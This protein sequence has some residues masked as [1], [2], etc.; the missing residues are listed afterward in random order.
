MRIRRPTIRGLSVGVFAVCLLFP[1]EAQLSG[2]NRLVPFENILK[3]TQAFLVVDLTTLKKRSTSKLLQVP[4]KEAL[5]FEFEEQSVTVVDVLH[6]GDKLKDGRLKKGAS[7]RFVSVAVQR[8]CDYQIT[9]ATTGARRRMWYDHN[10]AFDEAP[11]GSKALLLLT[12]YDGE[13]K[14]YE[15]SMGCGLLPLGYINRLL[16][17][18]VGGGR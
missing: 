17:F 4:K 3:R 9:L 8:A 1:S 6:L 2:A 14:A 12:R 7:V 18:F 10:P 13:L 11:K 5:K 16:A 15:A